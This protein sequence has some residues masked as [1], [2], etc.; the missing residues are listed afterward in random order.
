M[1]PKI[2]MVCMCV[3][4]QSCTA[5]LATSRRGHRAHGADGGG[6]R[7]TFQSSRCGRCLP[8]SGLCLRW[9]SGG[10]AYAG[11]LVHRRKEAIFGLTMEI[12]DDTQIHPCKTPDVLSRQSTFT[13]VGTGNSTWFQP[14]HHRSF[15]RAHPAQLHTIHPWQNRFRPRNALHQLLSQ[16]PKICKR[17]K[18]LNMHY[19]L[20]QDS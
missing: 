20:R 14:Q 16:Q 1:L 19:D 17:K 6:T 11:H 2:G 5:R 4:H 3:T 15:P 8:H 9:G 12:P 18:E 13:N 7:A 10:K